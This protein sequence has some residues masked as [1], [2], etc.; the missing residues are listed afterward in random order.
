VFT[1]AT[2]LWG[3]LRKW[4]QYHTVRIDHY[5][6]TF[7]TGAEIEFEG[8]TW[9]EIDRIVKAYEEMLERRERRRLW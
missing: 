1:S 3:R 5:H 6:H 2:R 8:Y 9:Y 4:Y 7:S